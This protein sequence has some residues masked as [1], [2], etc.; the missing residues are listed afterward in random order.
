MRI[1]A[2]KLMACQSSLPEYFRES[3][4]ALLK[5]DSGQAGMTNCRRLKPCIGAEDGFTLVE[6]MI[7]MVVFVLAMVAASNIFSGLLSQFKQQSS[8]AESNIEGIS[9]LES[10]RHDIEQAGF[11]LP[12]NMSGAAYNEAD[13]NAKYDPAIAFTAN[14]YNDSTTSAPPRAVVVGNNVLM[15]GSDVLVIKAT[16]VATNAASQKWEY[17]VNNGGLPN[18]L[19]TWDGSAAE[20]IGGTDHVII[21]NPS[22]SVNNKRVL[23]NS[24]VFDVQ[25]NNVGF[26]FKN[27]GA[28]TYNPFEPPQGSFTAYLAYGIA[29]DCNNPPCLRMP[30]NRADF[31]IKRPADIPSRCQANT[32]VLYKATVNHGTGASAGQLTELP[33]LD[34]VLDMQVVFA[35]DTIGSGSANVWQGVP[36][37]G[38]VL[39]V[40]PLTGLP[41]TADRIRSTLKEIRIYLIVQ[42]GQRD[43]SYTYVN[44]D[45]TA[46]AADKNMIYVRDANLGNVY[47]AAKNGY[48]VPDLNYRWKLHTIVIT[49]YNL[50]Q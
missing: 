33:L 29:P 21:M 49:P 2:M 36:G 43:I 38:A 37:D 44:P 11:G 42:E 45:P 10:M 47:G 16:N 20:Q 34:C 23:M 22:A 14:A 48:A 46:P 17:I 39:P 27:G 3:G 35:L 19:R 26:S 1:Y 30:F 31:Y 4:I 5:N 24:G 8:I 32:G 40:D 41:M 25:L 9:G 18:T 13:P 12:W 28:S 7:T 15:N 50:Q 6:L